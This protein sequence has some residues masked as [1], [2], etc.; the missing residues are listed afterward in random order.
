MC[1]SDLGNA[2]RIY[3]RY[4][5]RSQHHILFLRMIANIL[6][7]SRLAGPCF[8]CQENRLASV[9]DQLQGILKLLIVRV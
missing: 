4:S 9:G 7:K 1:S 6:Q 2:A 5:G 8:P 3:G